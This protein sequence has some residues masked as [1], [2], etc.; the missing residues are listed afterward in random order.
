MQ[1]ANNADRSLR[2]GETGHQWE[3]VLSGAMGT[4]NVRQMQTIRVRATGA[5]TVTID[6]VLAMTMVS[7]EIALFCVGRGSNQNN[8]PGAAGSAYN[9]SIPVVIAGANAFVQVARDK[10]YP[11][12]AVANILA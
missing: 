2:T 6:G 9:A 8:T 1:A 4:V 5:T 12:P 3:E 10:D 7:G 11:A